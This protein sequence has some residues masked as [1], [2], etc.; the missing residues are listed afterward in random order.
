MNNDFYK[1]SEE[2]A[3]RNA[4]GIMNGNP[5][6]GLEN[7]TIKDPFGI[8]ASQMFNGQDDEFEEESLKPGP[9]K[10]SEYEEWFDSLSEEDQVEVHKQNLREAQMI[11]DSMPG[12][13][14]PGRNELC[15]ECLEKGIKH[16]FKNCK[17]HYY[18]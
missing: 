14:K 3:R 13:P 18:D 5:L 9:P 7:L 16:K 4:E 8:N 11:I 15:P 6:A 10:L 17:E 1:K 2:I 12:Q